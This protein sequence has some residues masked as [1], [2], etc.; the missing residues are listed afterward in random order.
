MLKIILFA[1]LP[2]YLF[3]ESFLISS[4]PLPKTQVLNLQTEPCNALCMQALYDEKKPFSLL[5]YSQD[6]TQEI[7]LDD[8]A[9]TEE[10]ATLKSLLNIIPLKGFD[11]FN[12]A[13]LIPQKK[14]GRYANSTTNAVFAYLLNQKGRFTIKSYTIENESIESI[15]EAVAQI[16]NEHYRYI[17][18]PVT[19][20]GAQNLVQLHIEPT[21]FIPTIHINEINASLDNYFFGGIDYQEQIVAL[22]HDAAPNLVIFQDRSTL[23]KRLHGYIESSFD[24]SDLNLSDYAL[25][26]RQ[27]EQNISAMP[28]QQIKTITIDKR[29]TNIARYVKEN[30]RIQYASFFLNTPVIKSGMIMSQLTLNDVNI[31]T[32]LSTQINYDPLILSITQYVDREQM[33]I[34]NSILFHDKQLIEENKLLHNDIVY[35]WINYSTTLAVDF[36]YSNY[37]KTPRIFPEPITNN[38]VQYPVELLQ[39]SYAKFNHYESVLPEREERIERLE[40]NNE[41]NSSKSLLDSL[42]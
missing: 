14:I 12:I 27:N 20:E 6:G 28:Q 9:V 15:E 30:E 2:L 21:V 1:L 41:D 10:I 34:A 4:I 38:Q 39:P 26:S 31:S 35:D 25:L 42:F 36:F 32:I 5:A 23:A 33:I 7:M 8:V 16:Q 13:L 17:I 29:T 3:G 19:L 37:H 22:L 24:T 18:A 11:T 40:E